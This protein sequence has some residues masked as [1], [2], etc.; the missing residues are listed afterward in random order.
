MESYY[1]TSTIIYFRFR[2]STAALKASGNKNAIIFSEARDRP[3]ESVAPPWQLTCVLT[4]T[5]QT[6][7]ASNCRR[8]AVHKRLNR[9]LLHWNK[10][11]IYLPRTQSH[12]LGSCNCQ[13]DPLFT[14]T[15]TDQ[16]VFPR[17]LNLSE[18]WRYYLSQTHL[19]N[20]SVVSP[21]GLLRSTVNSDNRWSP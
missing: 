9:R 6:D 14:H 2:F 8:N 10:N 3:T 15:I 4:S 21:P 16:T 11:P 13:V 19:I 20:L 17:N 1:V 12:W 5:V 7:F 18:L